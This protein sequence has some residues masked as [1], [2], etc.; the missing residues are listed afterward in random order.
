MDA[1]SNPITTE[2]VKSAVNT[3]PK[4]KSPGEDGLPSEF[5]MHFFG[6]L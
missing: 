5:Y 6:R 4:N 3:S 1:L 2:E